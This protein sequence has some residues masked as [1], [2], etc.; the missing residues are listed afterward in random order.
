MSLAGAGVA[1]ADLITIGAQQAG[2]NGGAIIGVTSGN[3][4][5]VFVG[6]YGNYSINID[7]ANG[8]PP[9]PE[10]NMTGTASATINP[11]ATG[12]L[13]IYIT[14]QGLTSPTGQY[15]LNSALSLSS[16]N[17]NTTLTESV[18]IDPSNGLYGTSPSAQLMA[19]R[20]FS[21]G[22]ATGH[23]VITV[24]P[25]ITGAYSETQVFTFNTT[26]ASNN[27]I[28][29]GGSITTNSVPEPGSLAL[30][31]TGLLGLGLIGRRRR[32]KA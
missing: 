3:G 26:T 9:N 6:G 14:E 25:N 13:S 10:P 7:T 20:T 12:S 30:L 17:P 1:Q 24:T 28:S 4:N 5:A 32:R 27:P 16:V 15:R 21:G 18:Y 8:T 29:S 22:S 11:G 19:T 2:V 31:G 23:S